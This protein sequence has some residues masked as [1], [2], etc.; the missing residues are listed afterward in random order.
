[1]KPPRLPW[2]TFP[3]VLIHASE[4]A[5]KQHPDYQAAKTG[6]AVAAARLLGDTVNDRQV[7][8]LRMLLAPHQPILVSAHAYEREGVNAI[9]EALADELSQRLGWPVDHGVVQTNMVA[10]TG[11]D[12]FARLARQAAFDGAVIAGAD[13]VLVDDFV[14]MGGTLANLRGFIESRGGHVLAA[15]ALTGKP[16]SSKLSVTDQRLAELRC[17]HGDEL[18]YWWQQRFAHAFDSLT[19]S[20]ARYLVRTPDID[21]VRD[22]IVAQ[23]QTGDC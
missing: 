6:S 8:A 23:E 2:H 16:H 3:D 18:E 14:G 5:V 11:A 17:K 13:Y 22:R 19:E 20:E 7:D 21:T 10:H 1:M 12:G 15:T 9:P 4:S